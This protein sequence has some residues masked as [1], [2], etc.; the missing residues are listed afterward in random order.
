MDDSTASAELIVK[1]RFSSES[2]IADPDALVPALPAAPATLPAA[3]TPPAPS[4]LALPALPPRPAAEDAVL[5]FLKIREP[6][7]LSI[8]EFREPFR[9]SL[10][11]LY[12]S[13]YLN[14][15]LARPREQSSARPTRSLL[16]DVRPKRWYQE[17]KSIKDAIRLAQ[18][19]LSRATAVLNALENGGSYPDGVDVAKHDHGIREARK[20]YLVAQDVLERLVQERNNLLQEMRVAGY[21]VHKDKVPEEMA[22]LGYDFFIAGGVPGYKD[23]EPIV[24]D[25]SLDLRED[26]AWNELE[27][28][29]RERLFANPR[30][31]PRS[32][33]RYLSKLGSL[34]DFGQYLPQIQKD[35]DALAGEI[36]L[37]RDAI[38]QQEKQLESAQKEIE[39]WKVDR[40]T[41]EEP[42]ASF[43]PYNADEYP[44]SGNASGPEN[45]ARFRNWLSSHATTLRAFVC[46][47]TASGDN[48]SITID[49]YKGFEWH[50]DYSV[51]KI[52]IM[53]HPNGVEVY[54]YNYTIKGDVEIRNFF[55]TA[56]R[57]CDSFIGQLQQEAEAS[58]TKIATLK[59][60]KTAVELRKKDL[61]VNGLRLAREGFVDDWN[62]ASIMETTAIGERIVS[63]NS[64]PLTDLIAEASR[65]TENPPRSIRSS[66]GRTATIPRT[67]SSFSTSSPWRRGSLTSPSSC[68][69]SLTAT[70]GGWKAS[71]TP[72]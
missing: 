70:E 68:F 63:P 41:L 53:V 1:E 21:V 55:A 40:K 66:T 67:A 69:P 46:K 72:W 36:G 8:I 4:L 13:L 23:Y 60:N 44:P 9:V 32:K 43:R 33:E 10:D 42:Q 38:A 64:D 15:D 65:T 26:R 34:G 59:N 5:P 30:F 24:V 56:I 61:E 35:L 20:K 22:E 37:L 11:S 25:P 3:S 7:A 19:D 49:K 14:S 47:L 17:Y 28:R 52:P 16:L 12:S 31:S 62:R 45:N 18:F 39:S 71:P 2:D 6:N 58:Q 48:Y 51:V 29:L 27:S 54:A 57:L 50:Q